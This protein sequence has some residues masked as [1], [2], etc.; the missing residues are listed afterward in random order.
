[1]DA[2]QTDPDGTA[3]IHAAAEAGHRPIVEFLVK[4][5]VHVDT[6][7]ANGRPPISF[8]AE[9]GHLAAAEGLLKLGA[10]IG[11]GEASPLLPAAA[12][13]RVQ[14]TLCLLDHRADATD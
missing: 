10:E 11:E 7:D 14:V 5:R 1:M 8:A 4:S 6:P 12:L 9:H 3:P 13:G 2:G